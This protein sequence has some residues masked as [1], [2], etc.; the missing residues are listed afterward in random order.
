MPRSGSQTARALQ[1]PPVAWPFHMRRCRHNTNRQES[2]GG[3]RG[4]GVGLRCR[5]LPFPR[6]CSALHPANE[7]LWKPPQYTAARAAVRWRGSHSPR[8]RRE[9]RESGSAAFFRDLRIATG[10][11]APTKYGIYRSLDGCV[12]RAALATNRRRVRPAASPRRPWPDGWRGSWR[13]RN[14]R[15][16]RRNPQ[17]DERTKVRSQEPRQKPMPSTSPM[18]LR[19]P[20]LP[21]LLAAPVPA[22]SGDPLSHGR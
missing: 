21:L 15:L 12:P 5:P 14:R 8:H 16:V 18:N 22:V 19:L 10:G 17:T 6:C 20:I 9:L 7:D 1:Q 11:A 2:T 3:H 13:T 4:A